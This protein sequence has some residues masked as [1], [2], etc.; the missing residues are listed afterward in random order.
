MIFLSYYKAKINNTVSAVM[1]KSTLQKD[2]QMLGFTK[3]L[4]A[5][6]LAL[7]ELG[8]TKAGE[9]V[10]KTGLHRHLV[11]TALDTLEDK[12][13]LS[14]TVKKGVQRFSP[15]NAHHLLEEVRRTEELAHHVINTIDSLKKKASQEVIVYEG[16]D[17]IV[18]L[19]RRTFTS[20]S[21]GMVYRYLGLANAWF[22]GTIKDGEIFE[23]A[24]I[25]K[26]KGFSSKGITNKLLP[27]EVE[28]ANVVEG[29]FEFKEIPHVTSK[30]V[31]IG[32]LADRLII[33]IFKE[34]YTGIEI[35]N[36]QLASEYNA[37]FDYLWNQEVVT[38]RGWDG[39][40]QL[41]F[42]EL[43]TDLK[44]GDTEFVIGANL[45]DTSEVRN[46]AMDFFARFNNA[47]RVKGANIQALFFEKDREH[48]KNQ[49]LESG[50]ITAGTAEIKYLQ[51][52]YWSPV[53]IDIFP[54]K[55]II[56]RMGEEPSATVYTDSSI[57]EGFKKQFDSHWEQEVQTYVG[58]DQ[59]RYLMFDTIFPNFEGNT[60]YAQGAGY[61]I[62][63]DTGAFEAF[64][65]EYNSRRIELGINRHV[66]MYEQYREQFEQ[67]ITDAG[68]PKHRLTH[69]RFLPKE[70]NSPMEI[71]IYGDTVVLIAW[72]GIPTAT[73]YSRSEMAKGFKNQFD[74]LW[75][76][77]KE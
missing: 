4:A 44:R 15:L 56:L 3:N 49:F 18:A 73:V 61:D 65:L 2:L 51:N 70:F 39:L 21:K 58:W 20:L 62:A 72:Q 13:L 33:R 45:G 67:E 53:G 68:D 71:H 34:P 14:R 55:A 69:M 9:I 52:K 27:G 29:L 24:E 38:Y 32:I 19:E 23:L 17:E 42:H 30:D 54:K 59:I 47:R 16:I 46:K 25:Q 8:E 35:V 63:E 6:Y 75:N 11:Y 28:F 50:D 10:K 7:V 64:W 48:A 1:T 57:V 43:L 40:E 36:K 41:Y 60:E 37:Y 31:E 12:K 76:I 26:Q 22:D 5:V 74:M 66:L 77:A